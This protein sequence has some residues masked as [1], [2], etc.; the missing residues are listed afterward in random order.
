MPQT[1]A[2]PTDPV[3]RI[4]LINR[5]VITP[6]DLVI[7]EEQLRQALVEVD[8]HE[9]Q[10]QERTSASMDVGQRSE[11]GQEVGAQSEHGQE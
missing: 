3:L 10:V 1:L 5:G 11:G 4:A 9:G 6:A 8:R 2:L 7:A